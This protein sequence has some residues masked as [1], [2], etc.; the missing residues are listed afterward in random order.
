M[1]RRKKCMH[2]SVEIFVANC[3][4]DLETYALE[5]ELARADIVRPAV[6]GNFVAAGDQSGGKMFSEGFEPAIVGG[7]SP[8]TEN[9]DAHDQLER[10]I[11]PGSSRITPVLF[12]FSQPGG[13]RSGLAAPSSS[14]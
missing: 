5:F 8:C 9:R 1:H 2:D 3:R 10:M 6:N 11:E 12:S 7:N 13:K 14:S 4:Q